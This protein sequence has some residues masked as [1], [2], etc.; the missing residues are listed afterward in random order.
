MPTAKDALLKYEAG[1]TSVAMSALT[2][3]GDHINFTGSFSPWSRKSGYA[4]VIR[5]NGLITGGA[6]TPSAAST[7]DAVDVTAA[8]AYI[9]G[10]LVT[11]AASTDEAV[12]R[13]T[14]GYLLL[15]LAAG[16]YTN[17][18]AGD[19]GKVVT[20][21]TTGDTATLV[22]YNNSTRQWL[23]AQVDGGDVFDD[24]DEAI[25]IAGGGTG[26]GSMS[27]VAVTPGY[28]INSVVMTSGGVI[29]V[30]EGYPGTSFS[31]TRGAIGGPPLIA[32][33]SV[34]MAQVRYTSASSADVDATEIFAVVGVHTE[35]WDYPVYDV[36]YYT[37]KITFVDDLPLIHTGGVAKKVYASYASPIF[38]DVSIATDFVPPEDSYSV[39]STQV[40]GRTVGSTSS[41]LGQGSF[42]AHLNNGVTDSLVTLEG[43]NLW[44]KFYPDRYAGPYIMCQ[45]TLGVTRA[46]PAGDQITASCTINAE[47][48][49]RNVAA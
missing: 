13:T 30:T 31:D 5:P 14:A 2:D 19:I 7:S 22:A 44:F 47:S 16:G 12:A 3:A 4:P 48:A 17:A 39:S 32:V 25:T 36:D 35:R 28:K 27:G 20:G 34:E 6:V 45:G 42:M 24:D 43:E 33:T 38:A 15:T 29:E 21:G 18:V 8:T 37:G 40:Y 1:Q 23:V 11:A 41:S 49:A 10:A 26:A 46:F 9:G